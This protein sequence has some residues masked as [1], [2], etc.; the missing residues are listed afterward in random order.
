MNK[1]LF[2]VLVTSLF[3]VFAFCLNK[4]QAQNL[5]DLTGWT[6]GSGTSGIFTMNGQASE[7]VREWGEGPNGNRVILWKAQPDGTSNADGGW[8]T[9]AFPIIHTNMYRF[10]VWLRKTNSNSGASYFGCRNVSTLSSV[11]T[12]NPYFWQGDLPQ[13]NKWYLLVGYIH[14]SGDTSIINYGGLYDG[15]SGAKVADAVDYKFEDGT[16]TSVHRAYL[17]NDPNLNDR[18]YFYA[19]RVDLVN[20]NEPSLSELL[21]LQNLMSDQAYFAGKVGIKT[22]NPGDYDLA[23]NGKIRSKEV[24]VEAANWPD[25]VFQNGYKSMPLPELKKFIATNK[26]LPEIPSAKEVELK[27]VSLG[28][29]NKLLVKKIEELTLMFIDQYEQSKK[30]SEQINELKSEIAN[31]KEN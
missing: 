19:P 18:Q 22:A 14:G 9:Q 1:K 16:T 12:S 4:S 17:F 30:Q 28:E 23:V 31:L 2:K 27:G 13:L 25:Y 8:N 5:L 7:N 24:K 6:V 20:G 11:V 26:H 3:F 29:M 15:L 10:S 21:G